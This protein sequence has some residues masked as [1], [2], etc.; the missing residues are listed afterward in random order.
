MEVVEKLNKSL[1]S[2]KTIIIE[3]TVK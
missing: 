3:K 1:M 2:K